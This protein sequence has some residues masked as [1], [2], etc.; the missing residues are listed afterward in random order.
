MAR[1]GNCTRREVI[2]SMAAAVATAGMITPTEDADAETT[3]QPTP[4]GASIRIAAGRTQPGNTNWVQGSSPSEI[5]VV[6][7]T[8]SGKFTGVPIY[9]ASLSGKG[10]MYTV[11]GGS[12]IYAATSNSFGIHVKTVNGSPLNPATI[13]AAGGIYAWFINWHGIEM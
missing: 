10:G 12:D 5:Q 6:V 1:R 3:P 9:V 2:A 11:T 4:Q 13:K 8:T 7:D